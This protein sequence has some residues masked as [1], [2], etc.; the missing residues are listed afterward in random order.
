MD[1]QVPEAELHELFDSRLKLYQP[2]GGYRFSIDSLLLAWFA[3]G[4]CCGSVADLGT[5]CG[6]L[7]V[8]LARSG[9]VRKIVGIEIQPELADLAARNT[10]L[11]EC[12]GKI[13]IAC[14]DI[15]S[16]GKLAGPESFDAVVTN[17]PF[18]P[19]GT[20]RINPAAQKAAARHELHGTIEDFMGAS[21]FFLKRGGRCDLIYPASRLVDLI[22]A[23]RHNKLE[24][25]LLR[26][27]HSRA[28]EPASMVLVEALKGAGAEM[29]I[30]SPLVLYVS[31]GTYSEEA[32]HVFANL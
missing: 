3:R 18:Y 5:G 17:P 1:E 7:P 6:V 19:C 26:F 16:P 13:T 24:P 31:P 29:K 20:G 22:A 28:G 30:E 4:R 8:L 23:M 12:D 32:L 9:A 21:A 2:A 27:V 15:R 25:K 14:G 10:G 11:N